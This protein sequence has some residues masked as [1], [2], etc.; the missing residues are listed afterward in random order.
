MPA[1]LDDLMQH[2]LIGYDHH[3]P[4][5]RKWLARFPAFAR[6]ALAL[7][8]DSDLAQLGAIRAGFGIGWCQAGLAA[9]DARLVRILP[10]ECS[11][12]LPTWIAMHEDLRSSPRCAAAFKALVD[13]LLGYI[14]TA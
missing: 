14:G 3:S 11:L 10:A 12:P 1:K 4:A 5:I 9:R 7:R 13:G 2:A 6:G 8:C